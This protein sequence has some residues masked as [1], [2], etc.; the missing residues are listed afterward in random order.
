MGVSGDVIAA[1]LGAHAALRAA[2]AGAGHSDRLEEGPVAAA[3]YGDRENRGGCEDSHS[4]R[5]GAPA[6]RQHGSAWYRVHVS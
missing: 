2:R 1:L 6:Q 5:G 4:A 3:G